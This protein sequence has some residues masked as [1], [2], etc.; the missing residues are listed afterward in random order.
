MKHSTGVLSFND[1]RGM[2]FLYSATSDIS[3]CDTSLK[4]ISLGDSTLT[5]ECSFRARCDGV[6]GSEGQILLYTTRPNVG[7][8]IALHYVESIDP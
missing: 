5:L 8:N 2:L 6:P 1:F 3:F 4:S 7:W